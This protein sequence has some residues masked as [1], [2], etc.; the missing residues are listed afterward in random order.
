[1]P[2]SFFFVG[3]VVEWQ[4]RYIHIRNKGILW[5]NVWLYGKKVVHRETQCEVEW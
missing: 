4:E 3:L 1:L 2:L 5:E